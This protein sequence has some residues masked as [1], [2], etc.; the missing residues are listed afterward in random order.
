[1][2]QV[3]GSVVAGS[4]LMGFQQ[5]KHRVFAGFSTELGI[6]LWLKLAESSSKWSHFQCMSRGRMMTT[7]INWVFHS[8]LRYPERTR[9]INS[10]IVWFLLKLLPQAAKT[11]LSHLLILLNPRLPKRR[12]LNLGLVDPL[13]FSERYGCPP[14]WIVLSASISVS[15]TIIYIYIYYVIICTYIDIY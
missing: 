4:M 10:G 7:T 5:P 11:K 12:F 3:C 6:W 2:G 9:W 14:A 15:P 1:M 13:A 8:M